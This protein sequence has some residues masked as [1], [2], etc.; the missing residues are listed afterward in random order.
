MRPSFI[1]QTD[2]TRWQHELESDSTLPPVA[3]HSSII[4]EVCFAGLW[5]VE[6]LID[7]D[8]PDDVNV[9]LQTKAAKLSYGK[10]PW[11]VHQK[12]LSDYQKTTNQY[13]N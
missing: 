12:V 10:N 6:K 9:E 2:I 5:L 7:L 4:K 13:L 3:L 1:K 11:E 8:C